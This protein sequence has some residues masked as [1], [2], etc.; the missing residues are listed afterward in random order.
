[1]VTGPGPSSDYPLGN[2]SDSKQCSLIKLCPLLSS[3]DVTSRRDNCNLQTS[4]ALGRTFRTS[5]LN[6]IG[7][8]S[9]TIIIRCIVGVNP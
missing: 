2:A 8:N 3:G 6:S 5:W 4:K 9:F 1:M 7:I